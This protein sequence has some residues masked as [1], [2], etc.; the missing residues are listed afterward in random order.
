MGLKIY[1]DDFGTGYSSLSQL[2]SLAV[3]VVKIDRAFIHNL[4]GAGETI[5]QAALHIAK[6]LNYSVIAEGV[7]TSEQEAKL[8]SMGVNY[9]QGYHFAH[10]MD[11]KALSSWVQAHE[12]VH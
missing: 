5:I 7:E 2:Q 4:N 9:F 11:S 8:L 12:G 3:D 6:A 1:I 10:L